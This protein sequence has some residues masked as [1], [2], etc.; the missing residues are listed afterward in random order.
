MNGTVT[1]SIVVVVATSAGRLFGSA[2]GRNA[3]GAAAAPA[4]APPRPAPAAYAPGGVEGDALHLTGRSFDDIEREVL[5]WALRRNDGSRRRAARSLSMAR[6]T[7]CDKVKRYGLASDARPRAVNSP[8]S[9][10]PPT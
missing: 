1:P 10:R 6:S 9:V 4:P 7:F 5:S 3:G 8:E 2:R